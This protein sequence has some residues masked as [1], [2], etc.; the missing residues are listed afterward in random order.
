MKSTTFG[1]RAGA[2]GATMVVTLDLVWEHRGGQDDLPYIASDTGKGLSQL[3]QELGPAFEKEG[4]SL[5]FH[6]SVLSGDTG[7]EPRLLVNGRSFDDV[8]LEVAGEQRLCE[9]RRWEMGLPVI[10]PTVLLHDVPYT[11]VPELLL[12]KAL[13][14]AAG[15]I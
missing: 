4:I 2:D 1:E 14:R 6:D 10:L 8:L 11:S 7:G 15:I 5:S 3:L 12:R 13:L 9:G